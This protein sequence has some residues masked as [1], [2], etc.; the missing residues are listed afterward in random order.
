VAALALSLTVACGVLAGLTVHSL[1]FHRMPK[2]ADRPAL[3]EELRMAWR[4]ALLVVLI[5][6]AM[7]GLALT[8][9]FTT[10]EGALWVVMLAALAVP[11]VAAVVLAVTTARPPRDVPQPVAVA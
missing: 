6:A 10:V 5:A 7:T 9:D 8:G 11:Y 2:R 1:P 4:E 3:I